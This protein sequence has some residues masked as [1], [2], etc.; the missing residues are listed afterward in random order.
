M[1]IIR[2]RILVFAIRAKGADVAGGLVHETVAD[3]F[4]FALEA[5]AAF[6]AGAFLDRAVVGAVLGVDVGVGAVGTGLV[7]GCT[8]AREITSACLAAVFSP[9]PCRGCENW[10]THFRRYCV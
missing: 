8:S 4:V 3:H 1:E 10:A 2:A 6:A 5:F 9:C 7:D